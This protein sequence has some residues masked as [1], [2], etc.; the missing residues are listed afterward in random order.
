[1]AN[2]EKSLMKCSFMSFGMEQS[3]KLMLSVLCQQ[4]KDE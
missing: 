1:M 2:G 3:S 4:R